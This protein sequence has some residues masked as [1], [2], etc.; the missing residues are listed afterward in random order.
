MNTV[1]LFWKSGVQEI[2]TITAILVSSM[3]CSSKSRNLAAAISYN[4]FTNNKTSSKN[5]IYKF[6]QS[7]CIINL[8]WNRG[9][10]QA[11]LTRKAT[12]IWTDNKVSVPRMA[13]LEDGDRK[14][15]SNPMTEMWCRLQEV[16]VLSIGCIIFTL[17]LTFLFYLFVFLFY[18][19]MIYTIIF[20]KF[21]FLLWSYLLKVRR[22]F[23][24]YFC[25]TP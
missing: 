11:Y 6:C 3:Q 19:F 10:K 13:A 4:T 9:I 17:P 5:E 22:D 1:C 14:L 7:F 24:T 20:L 25:F 15:P 8:N 16:I 2:I 18:I 21:C 23:V 12:D